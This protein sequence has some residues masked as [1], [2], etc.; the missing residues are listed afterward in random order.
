[1][2]PKIVL[3]VTSIAIALSLTVVFILR[4]L[5]GFFS[6]LVIIILFTVGEGVLLFGVFERRAPLFGKI[7]WK[8]TSNNG[9]VFIT[10]DD[11]P[12]EPYTSQILDILAQ[13]NVK[14][15]FFTIGENAARYPEVVRRII[16]EGHAIGNHTYTHDV[17]PLKSPRY[18]R[19]QIRRTSD[20]IELFTGLRPTFFRAPHGWRNPWV[21]KIAKEEGCIPVAW[22]L[23]VWDTDRPGAEKIIA[24]TVKG[25]KN[26]C[27][28]L[29]HD[30][31]GVESKADSSQLAEALPIIIQRTTTMGYTFLTLSKILKEPAK[32]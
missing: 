23:G 27:I 14:A 19:D 25:M 1:M 20:L 6:P 16:K 30:G 12:N 9:A 29:L 15:T 18:I 22:T 7:I 21:N 10:F 11:G 26:G 31:R 2:I 17:L 24:R 3:I 8:S 4:L 28:L 13:Y 32:R 5:T